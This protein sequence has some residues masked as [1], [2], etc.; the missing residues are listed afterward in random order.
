MAEFTHTLSQ[1]K[2]IESR[3]GNKASAMIR[4]ELQANVS[5]IFGVSQNI[6]TSLLESI[7]VRRKMYKHRLVRIAIN[8]ARHGFVFQHGVTKGR[9]SHIRERNT[10][11]RK[12]Y[13]VKDHGFILAK[14]PF[15]EVAVEK[16]G[17]FEYVFNE[18]GKIR[19]EQIS[20]A[21]AKSDIKIQ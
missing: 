20:F 16:S 12:F 3:I 17:A 13:T 8:M 11:V 18:L 5:S 7:E 1:V 21:F 14:K 19:M 2:R 10:P 15:I 9:T 4:K 6:D